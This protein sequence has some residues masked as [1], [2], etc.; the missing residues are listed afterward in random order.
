MTIHRFL[1]CLPEGKSP[2]GFP[3]WN[4]HPQFP[5][6]HRLATPKTL[7]LK[8]RP[9]LQRGFQRCFVK[10]LTLIWEGSI[11][12]RSAKWFINY[13]SNCESLL[14]IFNHQPS[15]SLHRFLLKMMR[16]KGTP[17]TQDTSIP[18][19]T[20]TSMTSKTSGRSFQVSAHPR[21][22]EVILGEKPWKIS[23][24]W[25]VHQLSMAMFNSFLLTFTRG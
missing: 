6:W 2:E 13:K 25:W 21:C 15:L 1:V 5:P 4:C 16:T 8:S 14:A 24:L 3:S 9:T 23:I 10:I 20:A 7:E 19:A 17:M 18:Q 22:G 11:N 12:G